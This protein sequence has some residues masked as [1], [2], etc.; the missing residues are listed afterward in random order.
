MIFNNTAKTILNGKTNLQVLNW[1]T[2]GY[3]RI[4]MYHRFG[5]T[6]DEDNKTFI[7]AFEQQVA[8]IRNNYCPMR[9]AELQRMV[10]S[11]E[12]PPSNA[13][14]LTVDDGYEDFFTYAYPILKK[15]GVP[16]TV[17]VTFNFLERK[18]W[19]WPD[20]LKFILKNSRFNEISV[21]DREFQRKFSLE[22]ECNQQSA[23]S[24]I[25][26]YCLAIGHSRCIEFIDELG[27]DLD[28]KVPKH[29]TTDFRGLSWNHVRE[30]AAEGIEIGSHTNNHPR[31]TTIDEKALAH[32]IYDS[33]HSI[34]G[35]IDRE[36]SCFAFPF[37][38]RSD[39]DERSKQM[40]RDAGYRMAFAAYF[41][42]NFGNDPFEINRIAAQDD[43]REFNEDIHGKKVLKS[44]FENFLDKL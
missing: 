12:R 41:G 39:I 5:S 26:D 4:F 40:L 25:A 1:L 33:K 21:R 6:R 19:L 9:L 38:T 2:K 14:I 3:P 10:E 7:G 44:V 16:A 37:G 8:M 42:N 35:A 24:D 34:E 27:R 30:M 11:G 13:V 43:W 17:F 18:I 32:E 28:V 31:L 22:E 23:W 20:L 15:Y 29:P 36:V